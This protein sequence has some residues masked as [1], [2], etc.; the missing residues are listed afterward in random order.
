MYIFS[1]THVLVAAMIATAAVLGTDVGPC[2]LNI[3]L[4]ANATDV[5][6]A[7]GIWAPNLTAFAAGDFNFEGVNFTAEGKKL[8][9]S[10]LDANDLVLVTIGDKGLAATDDHR[11][12]RCHLCLKACGAA[13]LL[14][15]LWVDSLPNR[16]DPAGACG[17][18]GR[19]PVWTGLACFFLSFLKA[20]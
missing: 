3:T 15:F 16:R 14:W 20:R 19:C 6:A 2:P 12:D 5:L 7:N 13:L 18:T 4:R 9:E 8:N 1:I 11:C 17:Q 10:G